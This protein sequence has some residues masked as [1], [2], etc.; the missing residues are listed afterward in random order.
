MTTLKHLLLC[1]LLAFI[2]NPSEG[3][4]PTSIRLVSEEWI[5][6][7]QSDGQGLYWDIFRY[8]FEPAGVRVETDTMDYEDAVNYVRRGLADAW[9][10]SALN[11]KDFPLYPTWHYDAEIIS[12]VFDRSKQPAFKNIN[13]LSGKKVAWI[14]GY[15]YQKYVDVPMLKVEV[16]NRLNMLKM[17]K[18]GR[19]DYFL[20]PKIDATLAKKAYFPND[21]ALVIHEF[22]TEWLYPAFAN[23][24]KGERLR[25]IWDAR[26]P[27]IAGSKKMK[28]LFKQWGFTYPL[29]QSPLIK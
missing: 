28:S 25:E 16:D 2:A 11:E 10:A 8:V 18:I 13:S 7:T 12:I 5:R 4:E 29:D 6:A 1:C 3:E 19:I 17:L 27:E 22:K 21:D 23:T 24:P 9:V 15:D 20:D 26:M 14:T